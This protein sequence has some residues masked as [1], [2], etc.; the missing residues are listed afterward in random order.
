[1]TDSVLKA[2]AEMRRG[3][4]DILIVIIRKLEDEK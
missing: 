2:S 1:M 4:S 3:F